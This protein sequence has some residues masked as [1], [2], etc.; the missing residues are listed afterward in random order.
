M[1]SF[2]VQL[3]M[4]YQSRCRWDTSIRYLSDVLHMCIVKLCM[5]PA[6]LTIITSRLNITSTVHLPLWMHLCHAL[7]PHHPPLPHFLYHHQSY[8][9]WWNASTVASRMPSR[10]LLYIRNGIITFPGSSSASKSPTSAKL[11]QFR[12]SITTYHPSYTPFHRWGSCH[13]GLCW[14]P[15]PPIPK[16]IY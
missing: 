15:L 14:P 1:Q 7:A 2:K 13:H 8:T 11:R 16:N 10:Q 9:A 6:L 4:I 12:V 5:C 3:C